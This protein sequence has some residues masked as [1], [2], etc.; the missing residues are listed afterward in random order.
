MLPGTY[1]RVELYGQPPLA[2]DEYAPEETLEPVRLLQMSVTLRP[3][4]V[5]LPPGF[6]PGP[7]ADP[8]QV[9]S[10][11]WID[12]NGRP[13]RAQWFIPD[14]LVERV[15]LPFLVRRLD[16]GR[17]RGHVDLW[18]D[19]TRQWR[20][21]LNYNGFGEG[22][23]WEVPQATGVEYLRVDQPEQGTVAVSSTERGG[24]L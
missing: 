8:V 13:W 5:D 19:H 12:D 18:L 11:N 6:P 1:W 17:G 20:L 7:I 16:L 23:P 14:V 10:F 4:R 2:E 21:Q 3:H 24:Q 15:Q 9:L 22:R